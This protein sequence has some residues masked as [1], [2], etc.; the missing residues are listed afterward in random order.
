MLTFPQDAKGSHGS[1][2]NTLQDASDT[3]KQQRH[4]ELEKLYLTGFSYARPGDP[5]RTLADVSTLPTCNPAFALYGPPSWLCD[6]YA[7]DTAGDVVSPDEKLPHSSRLD[8]TFDIFGLG[9]ILLEIGL[10]KTIDDMYE[11]SMRSKSERRNRKGHTPGTTSSDPRECHDSSPASGLTL[12]EFQEPSS[13]LS[14]V[15]SLA[16]R[17]GLIYRDVVRKCLLLE[18]WRPLAQQ[19]TGEDNDKQSSCGNNEVEFLEAI[20]ASLSQCKA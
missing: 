5:D 14:L 10:W 9:I 13:L 11:D 3:K 7:L 19:V 6:K 17:A 15:D 12:R 16:S 18:G 1:S 8:A 2:T 4:Q 20:L